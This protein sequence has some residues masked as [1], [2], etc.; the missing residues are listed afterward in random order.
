ML[1]EGPSTTA[2]IHASMLHDKTPH[3]KSQDLVKTS[4][5]IQTVHDRTLNSLPYQRVAEAKNV[6]KEQLLNITEREDSCF[7]FSH[8]AQVGFENSNLQSQITMGS[9]Q[10]SYSAAML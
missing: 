4:Q 7:L 3:L 6:Y 9:V 5:R 1:T 10:I 8:E 2:T